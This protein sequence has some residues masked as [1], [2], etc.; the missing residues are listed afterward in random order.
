[1]AK[2]RSPVD[3]D[4]ERHY[5]LR[6]KPLL[7]D[8]PWVLRVTDYKKKPS[9]VFVVKQRLT[10]ETDRRPKAQKVDKPML[11]DRGLLYGESQR[12]SLPVVRAVVARVQGETGAPLE[13]QRFFPAKRITFRGNLPL[14]AEAG[15]KLALV[16]KLQERIRSMDRVELIARRVDRFTSEEAAYWLSRITN[17][18]DVSNRWAMAGMKTMLGGH[19]GD[20]AIGRVLEQL[21]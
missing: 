5:Q 2:D 6:L 20:E 19:S 21:R 1:M 13:L 12:R 7:D 14:D 16:F 17:F 9:P 10:P 18:G 15:A 4:L 3:W 11:R 8:A